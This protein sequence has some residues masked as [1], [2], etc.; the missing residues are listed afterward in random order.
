MIIVVE[1]ISAAGKTSWCE[2]NATRTVGE[3][4][5]IYPPDGDE[6]MIARFW[7][8]AHCRRWAEAEHIEA[9]SGTAYCDTDPIKLHYT[10]CLW[11][12]GRASKAEWTAAVA[13]HRLAVQS[14]RLGFAD[15]VVF[16][17]P[18]A[19]I[20]RRQKEADSS[21]QRRNFELHSQVGPALRE[22]Y[23]I[24][25]QMRSGRVLWHGEQITAVPSQE[26][27]D[28]RYSVAM[29]DAIVDRADRRAE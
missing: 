27:M 29:F 24:V 28:E 10:W 2:K 16:L 23:E 8:E 5:A 3:L 4:P 22:W 14:R 7:V 15:I 18:A 12:L 11:R 19:D 21:R 6:S 25:E 9:E 26:R 13:A 1:G 20:V 17:E